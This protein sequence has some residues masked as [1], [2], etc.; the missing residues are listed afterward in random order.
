MLFG[1]VGAGGLAASLVLPNFSTKEISRGYEVQG[2]VLPKGFWKSGWSGWA[3]PA[4]RLGAR[5]SQRQPGGRKRGHGD[6][7]GPGRTASWRGWPG[8]GRAE[9]AGKGT[10][11]SCQ[12]ACRTHP[13]NSQML[14]QP[15]KPPKRNDFRAL[16]L[17]RKKTLKIKLEFE[18]NAAAKP[19]RRRRARAAARVLF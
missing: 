1:H 5:L 13:G 3:G 15:S 8:R 17:R 18:T 19:R 2:S 14:S 6:A 9:S 4:G 11:G 7:S 16:R 12:K 10:P